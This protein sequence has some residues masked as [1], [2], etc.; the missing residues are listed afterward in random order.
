VALVAWAPQALAGLSPAVA[1]WVQPIA[2]VLVAFH[3]A[4]AGALVDGYQVG[5]RSVVNLET[6]GDDSI[7]SRYEEVAA[8]LPDDAVVMASD[9]VRWVLPT[10]A[11]KVVAVDRETFFVGDTVD[12]LDAAAAF[13]D[14]AVSQTERR[15]ILERWGAG[16]VV[17]DIADLDEATQRALDA[18]GEVLGSTPKL[19]LIAVG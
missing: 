6:T 2:M 4:L 19:R 7:V 8:A 13:F 10:F 5:L 14:P 11:G 15:D 18:L 12:R 3:V 1:R 16:F 17:Y 9:S